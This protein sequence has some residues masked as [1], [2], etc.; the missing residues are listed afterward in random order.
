MDGTKGVS[1]Y[2]GWLVAFRW[3][4]V[5]VR[6]R[7]RVYTIFKSMSTIFWNEW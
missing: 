1:R 4:T 6:V 7:V 3:V 5:T 2:L